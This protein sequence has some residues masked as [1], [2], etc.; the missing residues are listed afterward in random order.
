V[1]DPVQQNI[2][3][4]LFELLAINAIFRSDPQRSPLIPQEGPSGRQP[5]DFV[6]L[7]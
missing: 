4:N 1:L 5:V 7:A 2:Q 6:E 3:I